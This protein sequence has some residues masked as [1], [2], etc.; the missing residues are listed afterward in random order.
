MERDRWVGDF[1][2]MGG[3][4]AYVWSAFGV[5]ALA[6]VGLFGASWSASRRRAR[7][8]ER[9]QRRVESLDDG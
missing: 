5:T 1:L 7:E 2:A 6:L 4:G 3:Y 8:L 9:W